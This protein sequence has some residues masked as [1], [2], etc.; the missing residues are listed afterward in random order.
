MCCVIEMTR[1]T[2][3]A[4]QTYSLIFHRPLLPNGPYVSLPC[5]CR[6]TNVAGPPVV[7]SF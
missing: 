2:R 7:A 4:F 6:H 5:W 1:N 3:I